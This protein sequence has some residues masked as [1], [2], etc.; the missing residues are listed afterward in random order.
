MFLITVLPRGDRDAA[1][2]RW[3]DR[4]G[5]RARRALRKVAV[6]LFLAVVIGAIVAEHDT[7]LDNLGELARRGHHAEP[8]GDGDV[9]SRVSQLARLDD[10]QATAIALELGIHNATLAIAVA[11]RWRPS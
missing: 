4:V 9:A 6:G 11:A 7:V 10:R 3:P 8:G 5:R 1:P 2:G